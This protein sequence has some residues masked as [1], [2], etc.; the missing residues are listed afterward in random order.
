MVTRLVTRR[1]VLQ[2]L[3]GL[4]GLVVTL[5]CSFRRDP[6]G[7]SGGMVGGSEMGCRGMMGCATAADMSVYRDLFHRHTQLR[8]TVEEIPGGV[9]AT[10]ESDDPALV[11]QLQAHV[12]A[13]YQHLD[14]GR[15]ITCMSSTLPTLFRT[16]PATIGS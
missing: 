1:A 8:R 14:Q 7:H 13:M 9:R 2:A 10:T 5:S 11:A 4:A 12:A 6:P 16:R 15:E 3:A